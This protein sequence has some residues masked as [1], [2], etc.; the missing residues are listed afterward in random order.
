MRTIKLKLIAA[1]LAASFLLGGNV[2][3]ADE[4]TI[5]PGTVFYPG[6]SF[7]LSEDTYIYNVDP[8]PNPSQFEPGEYVF[9]GDFEWYW[10]EWL[11]DCVNTEMMWGFF[12]RA[13]WLR[14]VEQPVAVM[15]TGGD[16]RTMR[17]A[18]VFQIVVPMFRLY[19]PNSGEHFYTADVSERDALI[20]LGWNNEGV[21]WLAPGSSNTPVYRLYN[22]NGGEHHYTMSAGEHDALVAVGWEDEGIGWYSD[23][24]QTVPLYRQYNPNA[25]ANNHNYTTSI[26]EN[27]NLVSLGWRAEAIGWYGVG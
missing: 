2:V 13:D 6:D 14:G 22:R 27:N 4:K 26:E 12:F 9:T 19:N 15:C 16:G 17:T 24:A 25:F 23:D 3:I 18:F 1:G 5:Q 20:D 7:F 21:G 8:S 10:G 11:I